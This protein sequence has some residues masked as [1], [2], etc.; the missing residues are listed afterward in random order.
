MTTHL[1]ALG[2]AA[3]F[4]LMATPAQA[5]GGP[6][7]SDESFFE[8]MFT[9]E[10]LAHYFTPTK[11]SAQFVEVSNA[12]HADEAPEPDPEIYTGRIDITYSNHKSHQAARDFAYVSVI[13]LW[14]ERQNQNTFF[15]PS[16]AAIDYADEAQPQTPSIKIIYGDSAFA[17]GEKSPATSFGCVGS[18]FVVVAP[19]IKEVLLFGT[20]L[21]CATPDAYKKLRTNGPEQP[22]D[23]QEGNS[24]Y[25]F[26]PIVHQHAPQ[27]VK[28]LPSKASVAAAALK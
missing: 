25:G 27:P 5:D 26:D 13:S 7:A 14:F 4:G 18:K 6:D 16:A 8:R 20:M 9:T 21:H 15:E 24:G 12:W 10:Q 3:F 17:T 19:K 11:P 28:L 23:K 2:L 22:E 1:Q